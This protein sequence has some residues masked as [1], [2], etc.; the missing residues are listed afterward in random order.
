MVFTINYIFADTKIVI[1]KIGICLFLK[2]EQDLAL[3]WGVVLVLI[4]H[5]GI[6]NVFLQYL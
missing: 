5:L 1:F 4:F 6:I 3:K 2:A